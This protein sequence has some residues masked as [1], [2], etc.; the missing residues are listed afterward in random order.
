MDRKSNRDTLEDRVRRELADSIDEELEM[1]IDDDR[2]D[3]LVAEA[4][5]R[6]G[7]GG[8]LHVEH[9]G[10]AGAMF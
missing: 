4:T 10:A 5:E 7:E 3:G 1:E 8:G 6:A 2:M 9:V